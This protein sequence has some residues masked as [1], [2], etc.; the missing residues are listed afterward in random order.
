[1]TRRWLCALGVIVLAA[2]AASAQSR[3]ADALPPPA[4]PGW[5]PGAG[6]SPY[7][8]TTLPAQAG[9]TPVAAPVN[10]TWGEYGGVASGCGGA[11]PC[12]ASG[13]QCYAR[14][15]YLLWWVKNPRVPPLATT[16]PAEFVN[17]D[18]LPFT[19]TIFGG[20]TEDFQEFSGGRIT[21]GCWLD[22]A[23]C[24]GFQASYFQ[25]EHKFI[26]FEG[27]SN[28]DPILGRPIFDVGQGEPALI[29]FAVPGRSTGS[30]SAALSDRFWGADADLRTRVTS[31][32]SDRL[33]VFG[34]FRYLQLDEGLAAA[35]TA[36]FLPGVEPPPVVILPS[37]GQVVPVQ[38]L[39]DFD[40]FNTH[41]HFYG[42]DFGAEANY[43]FGRWY[44][45]AIG[46]LALGDNHEVVTINGSATA[47]STTGQVF[48]I[49][50]GLLAQP[51]NIGR[52]D[53]DHFAAVPEVTLNLG[54]HLT[55]NL[56]CFVGYNFLY[57][58]HVVRPGDQVDL[59]VNTTQV[60]GLGNGV[61]VGPAKPS[62]AFKDSDFWAQGV[63][64]GVALRY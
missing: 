52:Y 35:G 61:L 18:P 48:T 10:G 47:V 50:R 9:E 37:N 42:V 29:E 59:N 8:P 36:N 5:R 19:T 11:T 34:G 32:F 7:W 63:N 43:E 57:I 44:V 4:D 26:H 54:Y 6:V 17:Q 20:E 49:P 16:A 13:E 33:V 45:D 40:A 3:S 1:M 64:F 27:S 12:G 30:V 28:G 25:L 14:T 24:L 62:F 55:S 56:S 39:S 58:S 38:S 21:A 15:E 22:G 60:P 51:T 31:I 53:N 41:N 46:R 23:Q 2:S